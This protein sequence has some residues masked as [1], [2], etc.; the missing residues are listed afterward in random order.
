MRVGI[1]ECGAGNIGSVR[2]ALSFLGV[3]P[4][5]CRSPDDLADIDALVFPGVGHFR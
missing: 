1:V 3:D 4:K 5:T 2:R